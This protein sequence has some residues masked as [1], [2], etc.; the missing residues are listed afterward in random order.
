MVGNGVYKAG[1][2]GVVK[3]LAAGGGTAMPQIASRATVRGQAMVFER[4]DGIA[5]HQ[6]S[7]QVRANG[8]PLVAG[9]TDR[10]GAATHRCERSV[11]GGAR[12]PS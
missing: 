9:V 12:S 1:F 4:A 7:N 6:R 10:N 8:R 2:A 5:L 3:M 11:G